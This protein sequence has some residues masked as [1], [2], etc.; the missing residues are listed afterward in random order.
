MN[1]GSQVF[2]SE[3]ALKAYYDAE[4]QKEVD[5]DMMNEPNLLL[6][7]TSTHDGDRQDIDTYPDLCKEE[8]AVKTA[9]TELN[10]MIQ[11]DE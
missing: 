10:D 8:D 1:H 4:I 6:A 7:G 2:A 9:V 3:A 11:M 5:L